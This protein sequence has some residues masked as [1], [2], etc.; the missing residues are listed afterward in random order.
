MWKIRTREGS[1]TSI[2]MELHCDWKYNDCIEINEV[3]DDD[4]EPRKSKRTTAAIA[5]IKIR[6]KSEGKQGILTVQ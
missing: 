5:K 4:Q 3:N 1:T 6:V 2:P